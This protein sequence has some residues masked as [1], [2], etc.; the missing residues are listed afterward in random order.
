MAKKQKETEWCP[1]AKQIKIAELLLNPEDRRSKTE[2]MKEADVSRKCFYSWM[3]DRR[4]IDYLNDQLD[5]YT[6]GELAD[7][8]RSL[9]NQAKKGNIPAIKLY[10]EMKGLYVEKLEHSGETGVRIINDIPRNKPD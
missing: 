7:I 4:F 1:N 2:K 6:D 9:I 5:Q 8:W 10:F 3:K